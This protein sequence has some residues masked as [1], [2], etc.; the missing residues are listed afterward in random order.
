MTKSNRRTCNFWSQYA[1]GDGKGKKVGECEDCGSPLVQKN[2]IKYVCT[3]CG[4]EQEFQRKGKPR[5]QN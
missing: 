4:L 5:S 2:A 1:F 3:R